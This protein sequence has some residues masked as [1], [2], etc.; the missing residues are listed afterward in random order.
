MNFRIPEERREGHLTP[1]SEPAPPSCT[2][3]IPLPV[4]ALEGLSI[5]DAFV[6]KL[7]GKVCGISMSDSSEPWSRSSMQF[8]VESPDIPMKRGGVEEM[9]SDLERMEEE[10]RYA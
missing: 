7:K 6:L 8:E 4:T 2:V 9:M 10:S 5:G 3:D 1:M